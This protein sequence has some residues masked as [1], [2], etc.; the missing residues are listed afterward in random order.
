V[1]RRFNGELGDEARAIVR[2][3]IAAR[4]PDEEDVDF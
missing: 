3:L 2:G 4:D 1:L